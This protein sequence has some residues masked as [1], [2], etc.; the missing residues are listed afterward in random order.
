MANFGRT[1]A[2]KLRGAA[3]FLKQYRKQIKIAKVVGSGLAL[4][5]SGNDLFGYKLFLMTRNTDRKC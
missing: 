2:Q 3:E 4:S 1:L 5:G